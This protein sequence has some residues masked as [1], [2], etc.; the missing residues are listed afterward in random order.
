MS[1]ADQY[2]LAARGGGSFERQKLYFGDD[3]LLV[4]DGSTTERYRRLYYKDIQGLL[5]HPT[6]MSVIVQLLLVLI[7]LFS[8]MGIASGRDAPNWGGLFVFVPCAVIFAIMLYL[9]R[10]C[11]VGV[12][13][14]VQLVR[15][16][17]IGNIRK[18]RKFERQ[19]TER[20]EAV[21]GTLT[22]EALQAAQ[23]ATQSAV[24]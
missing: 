8:V 19:L 13:T 1:D 18:A 22:S 21:Q 23:N 4:I 24:T 15:L 16:P 12:K 20:V 11:A 3:H 5:W 7:M 14:R 2:K 17:A 10:S 6:A 9:G